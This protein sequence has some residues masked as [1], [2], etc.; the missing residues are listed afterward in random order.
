MNFLIAVLAVLLLA[1]SAFAQQ[2]P[3]QPPDPDLLAVKLD[4]CTS[5]LDVREKQVVQAAKQIDADRA[6][7]AAYVAGL[8][9][10]EKTQ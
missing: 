4:G 10:P 5:L 7:W 6:Y 1:T 2:Q 9:A 3:K 8:S